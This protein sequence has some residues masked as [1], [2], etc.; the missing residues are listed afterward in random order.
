VNANTAYNFAFTLTGSPSPTT[1]VTSGSLPPGITLSSSGVLSGSAIT[2]G[3]YTAT[4]TATNGVSP[5]ATTTFTIVVTPTVTIT[6]S[7]GPKGT[8]VTFNAA[9][10]V[11]GEK[12][13]F[14]Y[15]TGLSSPVSITVCKAT[16]T[17]SGTATCSGAIPTG[18]KQGPKGAH[19]IV[20]KGTASL[21][22]ATTIFTL[23]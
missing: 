9:G 2:A 10:F 21:I 4:V 23:T 11:P 6:P 12:V 22:K 5:D 1:S 16:V 8:A 15:K 13:K 14:N 19:T 7:S 18:G 17:A 20:A 3:S